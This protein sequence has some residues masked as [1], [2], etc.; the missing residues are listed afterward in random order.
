MI[1]LI[2]YVTFNQNMKGLKMTCWVIGWDSEGLESIFNWTESQNKYVEQTLRD[3]RTSDPSSVIEYMKLRAQ[4]NTHRN[5]E[6]YAV[7]IDE[8]IDADRIQQ[9]FEDNTNAFKELIRQKSHY[10]VW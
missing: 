8:E 7:N 4:F 5:P 2:L 9:Y 6:I 3:E 10:K 1:Y